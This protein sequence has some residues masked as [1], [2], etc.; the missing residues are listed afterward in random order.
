MASHIGKL[1]VA[2]P[3]GVEVTIDGQ[4]FAAKGA[5]G[6]DSYVIP[7]G[8]TAVV[9]GNEIVLTP[10]DDLRPTR[11]KHGLSRAIIASMVKGV[12]DGYEKHLLIV[13]TGYRAA[14]KGKSIEFSL[15]Y[16]HTITVDAP[17]GITFELPNPNEVVVKGTDKQQVGQIAANIRKLRAPEPYKGKGIK[18]A[19]EHI[20]RKAGKAGK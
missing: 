4:N 18:Y 12:H 1:P 3:A 6:S 7:E 13:G 8:I 20:L 9:E 16:S 5:K 10:A 14:M 11:A 2:I 15:G 17:E 19:D